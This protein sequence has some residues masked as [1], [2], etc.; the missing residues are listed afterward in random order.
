MVWSS[1]FRMDS[2]ECSCSG[3]SLLLVASCRVIGHEGLNNGVIVNIAPPLNDAALLAP[4]KIYS[5][6]VQSLLVDTLPMSASTTR[7]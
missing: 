1:C 2:S 3:S 6:N 4:R 5:S 7:C